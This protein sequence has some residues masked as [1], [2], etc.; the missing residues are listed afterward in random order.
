MAVGYGIGLPL[1]SY[2]L[3]DNFKY[4]PN[5]EANLRLLE[6]EPIQ[7][8]R[9]IYPFQ[10]IL[11]VLAHVS[12]VTLL[13]K[14]G[15]FQ[16]LFRRLEAVGQMALTNYVMQ[17]IICTLFFFG[18]GLNFY[19]DLQYYQLFYVVFTIWAL[20]LI[21]SPI[22]LGYCRFGP[23][24]WGWRSLTYWKIQPFLQPAGVPRES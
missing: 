16:A 4:H 15:R 19:G 17:S 14:S 18:Y 23:L 24:E 2:S 22:W 9:L 1:V 20:Q 21:I 13:Y 11:L 5:L 7:W 10:R 12:L 8:M 6:I 3:Y